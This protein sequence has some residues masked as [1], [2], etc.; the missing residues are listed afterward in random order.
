MSAQLVI[1]RNYQQFVEYLAKE[2][3]LNPEPHPDVYWFN[4]EQEAL[5]IETIRQLNQLIP[6]PPIKA[7]E[8]TLILVNFD[9]ATIPAQNAFLKMLEEHPSYVHF[10]LQA[11]NSHKILETIKSR[12]QVIN[13]Q[14]EKSP[15]ET[16]VAENF[17]AMLPQ[18]KPSTLIEWCEGHKDR[19]ET[20]AFLNDLLIQLHTLHRRQPTAQ[21]TLA[22]EQLNFALTQIEQNFNV[23]LTLENCVFAIKSRF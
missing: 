7:L 9:L 11:S 3:N 8:K 16:M 4:Q 15:A 17:L 13:L 22:L 23:L 12:C 14:P 6:Y 5:K 20:L 10:I 1:S 2:F 19:A 21:T 18:A